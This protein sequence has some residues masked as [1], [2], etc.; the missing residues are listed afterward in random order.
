MPRRIRERYRSAVFG[1][2]LIQGCDVLGDRDLAVVEFDRV[3]VGDLRFLEGGQQLRRRY[4]PSQRCPSPCG[5]CLCEAARRGRA[6][7][8]EGT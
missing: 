1:R 6:L 4:A 5:L 7:L 8:V 3:A 2:S